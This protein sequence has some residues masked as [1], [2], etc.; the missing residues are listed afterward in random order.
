[1]KFDAQS[2]NSKDYYIAL[3]KKVTYQTFPTS[4]PNLPQEAVDLF[5]RLRLDMNLLL[6]KI[7]ED[8]KSS[9]Q[10][11]MNSAI[12]EAYLRCLVVSGVLVPLTDSS[13]LCVDSSDQIH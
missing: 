2:D 8:A 1:M 4:N 3:M 5:E 6:E 13:A 11:D 12:E 7:S 9:P 10:V